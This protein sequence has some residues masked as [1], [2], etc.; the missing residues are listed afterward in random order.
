MTVAL[1]LGA[2]IGVALGLAVVFGIWRWR[3]LRM[4]LRRGDSDLEYFGD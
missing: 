4:R 1:L 3:R 2:V